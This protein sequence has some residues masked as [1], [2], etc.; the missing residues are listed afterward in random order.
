MQLTSQTL[1]KPKTSHG[2]PRHSRRIRKTGIFAHSRLD[3]LLLIVAAVQ[4]GVLLYGVLSFGSVS[5]PISLL[6]GLVSV[7][8]ICTNYQCVAHNFLHNPFFRSKRLNTAFSLFNTLLI[9]S[10]HSLYRIHH[11][12]HHKYNND[13]PDPQTGRVKDFTSTWRFSRRWGREENPVTYSLFAYFRNDFM[14]LFREAMRRRGVGLALCEA[15]VLLAMIA[16]FAILNPMGLLAFYLP[17][18]FLG[19]VA[20]MAENYVEHHGAIP[21]NRKTDSVS[22]YGKLYNWIW[23]NNGYHQEHHFQPQIH[24]TRV[25]EVKELLPPESERRV[26]KGAHWFNFGGAAAANRDSNR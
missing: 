17:M 12:H 6:L 4:F 21:G 18:W 2:A 23:F 11:L 7:F 22:S 24:W 26:V 15:A 9:G 3:S 16:A 10:P 14:F 5:W 19:N 25:A 20:A 13:A 8:L 1:A